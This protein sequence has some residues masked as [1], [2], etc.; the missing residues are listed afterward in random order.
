MN[1]ICSCY[2]WRPR[3]RIGESADRNLSKADAISTLMS[4]SH[5]LH[6]FLTMHALQIMSALGPW[7]IQVEAQVE[8]AA[9]V[10]SWQY[11]MEQLQQYGLLQ[12]SHFPTSRSQ[13]EQNRYPQLKQLSLHFL[14]A[15]LLQFPQNWTPGSRLQKPQLFPWHGSQSDSL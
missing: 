8:Q 6:A 5:L 15:H 14:H 2:E 10:H 9:A 12:P 13:S 7:S 11:L 4:R 1:I 3:L